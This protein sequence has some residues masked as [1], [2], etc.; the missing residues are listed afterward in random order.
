MLLLFYDHVKNR[1]LIIQI[2]SISPSWQPALL[3]NHLR[4]IQNHIVLFVAGT[5]GILVMLNVT[6]TVNI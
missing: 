2:P 5:F 4:S 6:A 1:S 3:P